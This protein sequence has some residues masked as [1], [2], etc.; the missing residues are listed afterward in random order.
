MLQI[1][2]KTYLLLIALLVSFISIS[3]K[4]KNIEEKEDEYILLDERVFTYTNQYNDKGLITKRGVEKI[5]LNKFGHMDELEEDLYFY[6]ELD[7]L[8]RKE[9]YIIN[10]NQKV[11]NIIELYSDSLM[12]EICFYNYPEDTLSYGYRKKNE[13]QQIIEEYNKLYLSTTQAENISYRQYDDLGRLSA[14]TWIDIVENETIEQIYNYSF[15]ADTLIT[16]MYKNDVQTWQSKKYEE[17]GTKIETSIDMISQ[18]VDTLYSN[19]KEN[20]SVK[21]DKDDKV[22]NIEE[23]DEHARLSFLLF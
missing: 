8:I 9:S 4:K 10:G 6:N 22:Q 23:F 2:I 21:Y 3:C 11:L 12:E 1:D 17:D 7:S 13:N 16:T 14:I 19:I 18:S 20:Y 15:D 5:S